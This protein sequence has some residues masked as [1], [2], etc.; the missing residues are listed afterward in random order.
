MDHMGGEAVGWVPATD[1]YEVSLAAGK[2]IARKNGSRLKTVP[3]QLKDH[4]SV[5]GLRQLVEWLVRHEAECQRTVQDWLIRSLP[6]P[7]R[8]VAAVWPDESWRTALSGL[9]VAPMNERGWDEANVGFLR[10]VDADGRLGVVDLDGESGWWSADRL[11][12]PHPVLLSDVDELRQFAT[13]LDVTQ[14]VLQ[15]F[16]EIWHKPDNPAQLAKEAAQYAGGEFA[17]LRHLT[18]RAASLGYAVRGG[19]ATVR[20]WDDGHMVDARVWVGADDPSYQTATGE[21]EFVADTG[22][23]IALEAVGPVSWSEGLR[24]AAA[25]YAGRVVEREAA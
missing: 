24:M 9:V 18:S 6:V 25:L 5:V 2:V 20:L 19:Y 11:V 12:I 16:R 23:A 8:V 15:L 1:G 3:K 21:L 22:A 14:G 4:D 17:Q 7:T 13:E 10:A